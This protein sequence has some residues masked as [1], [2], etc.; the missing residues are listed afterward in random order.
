MMDANMEIG[1]ADFSSSLSVYTHPYKLCERG[2]EAGSEGLWRGDSVYFPS[3]S[4]GRE[5][6]TQTSSLREGPSYLYTHPYDEK[7]NTRKEENLLRTLVCDWGWC[8]L[9]E[10]RRGREGRSRRR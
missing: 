7:V 8:C 9:S 10:E 5:L 2:R 6:Q 3:S 4:L 1:I